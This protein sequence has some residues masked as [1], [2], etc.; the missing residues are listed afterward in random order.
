MAVFIVFRPSIAERFLRSFASSA[1]AH[2]TEQA[3]RL[4][5]GSSMVNFASSMWCPVVFWF[6]GWSILVS[7]AGLLLIPWRW[8][9]RF[10]LQV[11]PPVYRHLKLFALGA[12]L[13]GVFI[14]YGSTH[15][16]T[17]MPTQDEHLAN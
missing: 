17:Q 9:H 5:V 15:A 6:F 7:T 14:L 8:H 3:L 2:Y 4:L 16:P 1:F 12:F 10:A 13:L 11:M